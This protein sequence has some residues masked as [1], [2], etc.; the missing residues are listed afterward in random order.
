MMSEIPMANWKEMFLLFVGRRIGFKV[1][2]DSM[3]PTLRNGDRVLVDPKRTI[4]MGDIVLANHPYKQNILIIKR[5]TS[6]D[7]DANY[8]L[9]GDN[10]A[11]STDSQ[12]FGKIPSKHVL[13]KVVAQM[14]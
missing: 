6:I 14:C 1:T 3:T 11:E 8:F 12:T 4:A 7:S 10:P 5:V 2:G 9:A 13:G